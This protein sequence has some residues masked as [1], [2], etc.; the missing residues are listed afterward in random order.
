MQAIITH[1]AK[2]KPY[3]PY[4]QHY[5]SLSLSLSVC[6]CVCVNSGWIKMAIRKKKLSHWRHGGAKVKPQKSSKTQSSKSQSSRLEPSQWC[7]CLARRKTSPNAMT[8]MITMMIPSLRLTPN[9]ATT[10]NATTR[11]L[12]SW[13]SF[14]FLGFCF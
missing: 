9:F 5:T 7:T 4:K 8:M 2:H 14:L 6:V 1:T 13:F 12:F 10:F 3:H 11:S